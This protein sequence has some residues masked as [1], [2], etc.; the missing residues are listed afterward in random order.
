MAHNPLK[1]LGHDCPK[2]VA[3]RPANWTIVPL[4]RAGRNHC[5]SATVMLSSRHEYFRP[6]VMS[7]AQERLVSGESQLMLAAVKARRDAGE[8]IP[9]EELIPIQSAKI[10]ELKAA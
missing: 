7:T 3:N 8:E 4:S 1:M 2:T 6:Q 9:A 5:N 10:R